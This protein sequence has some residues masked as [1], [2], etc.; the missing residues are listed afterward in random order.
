[1]HHAACKSRRLAHTGM[2]APRIAIGKSWKARGDRLT[3][4]RV[5][6]RFRPDSFAIGLFVVG[7]LLLA[8]PLTVIPGIVATVL[9]L[10]YWSIMTLLRALGGKARE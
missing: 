2:V 1:M 8:L 5:S 7:V 10:V 6:V 3:L 4:P 9:A